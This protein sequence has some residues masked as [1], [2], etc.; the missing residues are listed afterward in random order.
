MTVI[1]VWQKARMRIRRKIQSS[2]GGYRSHF[3][4]YLEAVCFGMNCMNKSGVCEIR[5]IKNLFA[6]K[7]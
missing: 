5:I 4:K 3:R 1:T 7:E 6:E 2:T